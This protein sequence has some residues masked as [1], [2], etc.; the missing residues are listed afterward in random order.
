MNT[1]NI[2]VRPLADRQ[3]EVTELLRQELPKDAYESVARGFTSDAP[4]WKVL[5]AALGR[6]TWE[7]FWAVYRDS[8]EAAA[9]KILTAREAPKKPPTP[10]G[11]LD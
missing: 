11:G 4:K 8:V 1:M 10:F 9:D 7:K 3:R 2:D 5:A 6:E